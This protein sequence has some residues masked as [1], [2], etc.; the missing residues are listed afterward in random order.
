MNIVPIPPGKKVIGCKWVYKVK[1]KADSSSKR[2]KARLVAMGYNKEYGLDFLE[3]FS[4]V[5]KITT[6]SS[7]IGIATSKDWS[8][9]QLDINNA[10]LHGDPHENIC[11]KVS[12]NLHI[13]PPKVNLQML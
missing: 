4:P 11:M 10:F 13:F 1:L 8:L 12:S 7:I 2:Y 9:S 3:T 5:V 6:I